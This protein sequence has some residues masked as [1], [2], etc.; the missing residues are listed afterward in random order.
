MTRVLDSWW[1]IGSFLGAVLLN[2]VLFDRNNI[3]EW[4]GI[5]L[6]GIVIFLVVA[7]AIHS[8]LMGLIGVAA[9]VALVVIGIIVKLRGSGDSSPIKK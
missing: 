5:S 6:A 8:P 1:T 4:Y 3:G 9:M 2:L 7:G